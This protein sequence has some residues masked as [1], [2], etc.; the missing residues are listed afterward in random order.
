MSSN[1]TEKFIRK[2][3]ELNNRLAKPFYTEKY[4]TTMWIRVNNIYLVTVAKRILNVIS[5]LQNARGHFRQF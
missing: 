3:L 1:I 4:I 5:V 2:F